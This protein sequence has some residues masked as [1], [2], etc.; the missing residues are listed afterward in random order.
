MNRRTFIKGLAVAPIAAAAAVIPA[1]SAPAAPAL[2]SRRVVKYW[3]G[4]ITGLIRD[5]E[6]GLLTPNE[7]RAKMEAAYDAAGEEVMIAMGSQQAAAQRYFKTH[8]I[9]L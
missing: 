2:P 9:R 5:A 7:F 6:A 1:S 8:P 4:V 3:G